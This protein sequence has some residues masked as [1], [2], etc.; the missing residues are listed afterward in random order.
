MVKIRAVD[1]SLMNLTDFVELV[2]ASGEIISP[3]VKKLTQEP[4]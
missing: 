1:L 2:K 4:S 3:I